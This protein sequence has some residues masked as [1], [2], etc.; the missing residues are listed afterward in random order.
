MRS[1][2]QTAM[3]NGISSRAVF[4]F[5]ADG[6]TMHR[7][8]SKPPAILIRQML[9]TVRLSTV[10]VRTPQA[11]AAA[12]VRQMAEGHRRVTSVRGSSVQTAFVNAAVV[13]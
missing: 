13:I 5:S 10:Y 4:S 6:I 8:I 9:N 2:L 11:M 3:R 7:N 12:T 1:V